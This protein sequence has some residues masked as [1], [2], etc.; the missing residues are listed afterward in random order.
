LEIQ[1][2]FEILQPIKF[3]WNKEEQPEQQEE[4]VI[5]PIYKKSDKTDCSNY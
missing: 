3:I 4:S 5:L 1:A 2:A